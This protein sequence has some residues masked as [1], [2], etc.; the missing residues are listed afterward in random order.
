MREEIDVTA[1]RAVTPETQASVMSAIRDTLQAA[2]Y[3]P[4]DFIRKTPDT[5]ALDEALTK[6]A[7][8]EHL[9]P[10]RVETT[11][12]ETLRFTKQRAETKKAS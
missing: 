1:L 8:F 7:L 12:V 9:K 11:S 2:G 3:D 10:L 6:P 5:A 4:A